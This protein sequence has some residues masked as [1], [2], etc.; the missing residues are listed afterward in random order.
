MADEIED[1][2]SLYEKKLNK[3]LQDSERQLEI[4][5]GM[6]EVGLV[7]SLKVRRKKDIEYVHTETK[8]FYDSYFQLDNEPYLRLLAVFYNA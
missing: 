8:K 4:Q 1:K 2:L 5:F 7:K 3:W 6:E